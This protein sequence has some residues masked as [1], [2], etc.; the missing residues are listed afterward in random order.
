MYILKDQLQFDAIFSGVFLTFAA[1]AIVLSTKQ[2][3][4]K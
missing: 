3:G 1:T 2:W 4:T